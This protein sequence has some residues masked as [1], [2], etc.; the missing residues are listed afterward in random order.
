MNCDLPSIVAGRSPICFNAF[1]SELTFVVFFFLLYFTFSMFF[2][3]L[4]HLFP[5]FSFIFSCFPIF[6]RGEKFQLHPLA[7]SPPA[8]PGASLG[9]S[10]ATWQAAVPRWL[11]TTTNMV[12]VSIILH[13][14]AFI[15]IYI[16]SHIM[17]DKYLVV[18]HTDYIETIWFMAYLIYIYS[19]SML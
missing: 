16:F 3:Y 19:Y 15:Y 4:T 8:S 9:R 12:D 5:S 10:V 1:P 7:P 14:I 6:H 2:L 18:W 17:I 11:D 13:Y